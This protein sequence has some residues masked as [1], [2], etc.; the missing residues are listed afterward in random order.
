[1]LPET[2]PSTASRKLRQ[3]LW[4]RARSAARGVPWFA[5]VKWSLF[6]ALLLSF[7][8]ATASAVAA[9]YAV[10]WGCLDPAWRKTGRDSGTLRT[11]RAV[12]TLR[13]CFRMIDETDRL[14]DV[15]SAPAAEETDL[16][17]QLDDAMLARRAGGG[18]RPLT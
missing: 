7:P 18:G 8:L 2:A 15:A 11:A 14:R 13:D 9:W 3:Q 1:M 17:Q 16:L 5:L 6:L 4:V 10:R 12:D